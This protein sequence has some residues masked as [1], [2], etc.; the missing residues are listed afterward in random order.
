MRRAPTGACGPVAG[1]DPDR[2][3][4]LEA[5][6]A[7]AAGRRY[8]RRGVE[9]H[10]RH[11]FRQD[12][13]RPRLG[14]RDGRSSAAR[15][16]AKTPAE[17]RVVIRDMLGHLGLSHFALI[18]AGTRRSA[19]AAPLRPT[20]AAHPGLEFGCIAR[21]LVVTRVDPDGGAAGARR[22]GGLESAVHQWR[23]DRPPAWRL[24]ETRQRAPAKCRGLAN[25]ADPP[26]RSVGIEVEVT[27]E[28]GEGSRSRPRIERRPEQGKPVTVG[29]L[30]TMFVRV[31]RRRA[32]AT[33]CGGDG[34]RDRVQRVDDGG[35]SRSSSRR[36]TN[37]VAP[38]ASS[39]IC[40]AILAGSR[41]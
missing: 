26:A 8:V 23:R 10:S 25:R 36:W 35:R 1:P 12:D 32:K 18:P 27:F 30:P 16:R 39:S 7:G 9:N 3:V 33:P 28:D 22:A 4:R 24:P 31:S 41:R 37:S 29:S 38:T 21:D 15:G 20:P 13:E 40:A 2:G 34:R 19:T 5:R 14:R 17:L 6:R 11:A